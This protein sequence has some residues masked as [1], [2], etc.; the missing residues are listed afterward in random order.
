M[1]IKSAEGVSYVAIF[2]DMKK[3][4]KPEEM[5]FTVQGIGNTRSKDFLV[6]LKYPKEDR[7]RLDSAHRKLISAKK[8]KRICAAI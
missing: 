8:R 3:R 4:F 2:K 5:S 1:L 6:K 7:G